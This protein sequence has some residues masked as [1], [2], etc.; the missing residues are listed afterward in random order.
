MRIPGLKTARQVA[1]QFR[2]RV[3]GG[4]IILGYHRICDEEHDPF[5]MSVSPRN[6]AEQLQVIKDL[7]VPISLQA[8]VQD[9]NEGKL[10][11]RAIALT[12]DDGYADNLYEARPLLGKFEIPATIFVIS[13][14]LSQ[15]FWWDKLVRL[16]FSEGV[17]SRGLCLRIAEQDYKW[18]LQANQEDN[19]QKTQLLWDLYRALRPLSNQGRQQSMDI[20]RDSVGD[21]QISKQKHRALTLSELKRLAGSPQIEIGSHTQTHPLLTKLSRS[22]QKDEI[23]QSKVYLEAVLKQPV[24]NFSYPNGLLTKET[25]AL[26]CEA[27][28]LSACGSENDTIRQGSDRFSL[29]RFWIPNWN[30]KQFANWL[31]KWL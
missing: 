24:A 26:V 16:V 31:T 30:G 5:S 2:S 18:Q 4:T 15:E 23:Q 8:L 9:L 22:E 1:R 19:N 14:C 17:F 3:L 13:G 27:G 21:V 10:P 29:S 25:R 11:R 28:F 20:L 12:M 6:F 7:A